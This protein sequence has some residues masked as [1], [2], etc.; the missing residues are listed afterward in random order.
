MKVYNGSVCGFVGQVGHFECKYWW[1]FWI[2][3]T[4]RAL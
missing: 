3:G 4:G 2:G 1:C